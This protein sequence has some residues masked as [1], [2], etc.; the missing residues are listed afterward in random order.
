MHRDALD[1]KPTDLDVKTVLENQ[2]L[3][4]RRRKMYMV[5][6]IWYVLHALMK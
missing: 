3:I 2:W 1:P 5:L 4:Q 6:V